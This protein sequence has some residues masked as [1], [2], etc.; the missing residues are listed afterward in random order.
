MET[1][2]R[3]IVRADL[4]D[5]TKMTL[6]QESS[7]SLAEYSFDPA[8]NTG[9]FNTT[10]SKGG[11]NY[12][13]GLL[14]STSKSKSHSR[15]TTPSGVIGVRGT[16]IEAICGSDGVLSISVPSG[17][18]DI[19]VIATDGS[20]TTQTVGVDGNT[21][22]ATVDSTGKVVL[23]QTLPP[24]LA[25]AITQMV[26]LVVAAE[27]AAANDPASAAGDPDAVA[28]NAVDPNVVNPD[29]PAV[30]TNLDVNI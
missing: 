7:A 14:G 8:D 5:G 15:I 4:S 10:V 30:T 2:A 25:A 23:L 27:T 17:N 11:F 22:I 16:V 24:E 9:G 12:S 29:P 21:A 18:V 19:T 20:S 26:E 28:P 6:R 13:S 1:G 3:S